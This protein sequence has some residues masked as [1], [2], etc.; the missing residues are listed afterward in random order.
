MSG[1]APNREGEIRNI[2]A[3]LL[4]EMQFLSAL[5]DM[6]RGGI[7][8]TESLVDIGDRIRKG[9][10]ALSEAS[11]RSLVP[12]DKDRKADWKSRFHGH[13]QHAVLLS[14]QP[15]AGNSVEHVVKEADRLVPMAF[16][17]EKS[18]TAYRTVYSILRS[19]CADRLLMQTTNGYARTVEGTEHLVRNGILEPNPPF[20]PISPG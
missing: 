19:L 10:V 16:A 4:T 5:L 12:D 13:L 17:G 6:P 20:N 8:I 15:G 3:E 1:T 11:M 9:G 2:A 18:L 7:D 14:C